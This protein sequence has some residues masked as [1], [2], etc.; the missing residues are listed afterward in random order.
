[1]LELG[2][3]PATLPAFVD[4][5]ICSIP[6]LFD[7]P[8]DKLVWHFSKNGVLSIQLAYHLAMDTL[9]KKEGCASTSNVSACEQ[10][11]KTIWSLNIPNKAPD[12]GVIKINF[13]A[14]RI[15]NGMMARL[16][17]IYGSF[18]RLKVVNFA[19]ELGFGNIHLEGDSLR[20]IHGILN[21]VVDL[22][23]RQDNSTAHYL[24]KQAIEANSELFWIEEVPDL[25]SLLVESEAL[26]REIVKQRRHSRSNQKEA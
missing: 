21:P 24:T 12:A 14:G 19:G 22:F 8:Q 20:V 13:D 4:E 11:R 17:A 9:A 10:P 26:Y 7:L 3:N 15:L 23:K 16:G 25:D 2:V 5:L 6:I 1:M 18:G